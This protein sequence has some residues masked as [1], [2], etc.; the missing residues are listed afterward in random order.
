MNGTIFGRQPVLVY[1][2]LAAVLN[3]AALW[4]EVT[5]LQIAAINGLILAGIGLLANSSLTPTGDARL[6]NGTQVNSGQSVVI[7]QSALNGT[8]AAN[9]LMPPAVDGAAPEKPVEP[10]RV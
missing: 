8:K 7:P 10:P 3:T 5:P 2:F 6:A 4:V 1:I 9:I